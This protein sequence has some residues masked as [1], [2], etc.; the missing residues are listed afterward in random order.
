VSAVAAQRHGGSGIAEGVDRAGEAVGRG[1]ESE[2]ARG[3]EGRSAGADCAQL[4]RGCFSPGGA[5]ARSGGCRAPGSADAG[6]AGKGIGRAAKDYLDRGLLLEAERLYHS[7]VAADGKLA[8]AHAGLAQV[9]ERTGDGEGARKEARAALELEPT[10][11]AYLVLGGWILRVEN[12]TRQAKRP[13]KH[14]SW[15][16]RIGRPRNFG[17]RSKPGKG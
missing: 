13:R 5:D 7:A 4:R 2:S 11:D 16:R 10:T 15:N 9:R 17:V 8:V 12:W 1:P 6:R 14:S 3:G